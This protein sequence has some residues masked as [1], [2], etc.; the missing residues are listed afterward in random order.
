MNGNLHNCVVFLQNFVQDFFLFFEQEEIT[1]SFFFLPFFFLLHRTA[2]AFKYAEARNRVKGFIHK[3]CTCHK[4]LHFRQFKM[5][6]TYKEKFIFIP[7][8]SKHRLFIFLPIDLYI[9]NP[10]H[11]T[12]H[13][14]KACWTTELKESTIQER[15]TL[16]PF[17]K[18]ML[19]P[20]QKFW[21]RDFHTNTCTSKK[22]QLR[23]VV[24]ISSKILVHP[25]FQSFIQLLFTLFVTV[26]FILQL[27][28]K[29]Q[30]QWIPTQLFN[31]YLSQLLQCIWTINSI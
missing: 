5:F 11:C 15:T 16:R 25:S 30:K 10:V 28:E 9:Y 8:L 21:N 19:S 22:E 12:A 26:Q 18:H 4:T 27:W 24:W 31:K 3:W 7:T 17:S 13:T 1:F 29:K 23:H 20:I 2:A 14:Y 6:Q